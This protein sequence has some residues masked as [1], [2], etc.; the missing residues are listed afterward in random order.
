MRIINGFKY[1]DDVNILLKYLYMSENNSILYKNAI[2]VEFKLN[3]NED[4]SL[5]KTTVTGAMPGQKFNG[6]E[7]SISD[8]IAIVE[9]LKD[10]P[11]IKFPDHFTNRFDEIKNMTL[12]STTLN[13]TKKRNND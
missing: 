12:Q 2:N 6:D 3:M 8:L 13:N 5:I 4:F 1:L 10:S 11:A 7:L 9:Q